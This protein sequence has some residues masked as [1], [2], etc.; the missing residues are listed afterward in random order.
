MAMKDYITIAITRETKAV[1]Q[2][3]FGYALIAGEFATSKT[4]TAFTR[5]RWYADTD[6]MLEDGWLTTDAEYKKA[7]AIMS[8]SPTVSKFG[9]GRKDALDASWT[10]ALT[11][12]AAENNEWYGL[13]IIPD[14]TEDT[15]YT[16][17]S[18]WTQSHK[19]IMGIQSSNL[20]ILDAAKSTDISSILKALAYD[21]TFVIYH[22]AAKS[23]ESA[24]AAW[25]GHEFPYAD[26]DIGTYA[27]KTLVGVTPDDLS[28][29][30]RAAAVAKN[31][32][33]YETTGGVNITAEGVMA[34]G[35]YIDIMIGTDWIESQMVSQVFSSL[36]NERKVPFGDGGI[37]GIA[38]IVKGVLSD[39]VDREILQ[40]D[41]YSVGYP[42]YADVP[43][44]S[45]ATRTLPNVTFKG[46]YLG[47]IQHVGI[48]GTLSV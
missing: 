5:F 10:E 48:Q 11:A 39:A 47:A 46:D 15:D 30:Q 19:K 12:I 40:D 26:T 43:Q 31:C 4:T 20:D 18:A 41:T 3:S 14:G 29:G 21:R 34:S 7:L 9:V 42:A 23:D 27:F 35:E 24:E 1:A 2:E 25:I 45:R 8:Q 36:V 44:A 32:N 33:V 37:I 38:G 22:A 13:V 28:T 6:E 17:A 16:E